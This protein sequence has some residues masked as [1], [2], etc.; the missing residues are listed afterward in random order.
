MLDSA[1]TAS[2]RLDFFAYYLY[3]GGKVP[4]AKHS[5]SLEALGQLKFRANENWKLCDGIEKVI[6]YCEAWEGKREKLPY[7][8]DGV[9]IKV[10]ATAIQNELGFHR[11]GPALGSR[12]QISGPARKLP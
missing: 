9:V 4:F 5:D 6:A 3:V 1:V 12:V 8:I 7:E 10:N 2:R 11:Q